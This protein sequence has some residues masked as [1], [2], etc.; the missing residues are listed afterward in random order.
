MIFDI[1]VYRG[2]DKS[3][4]LAVALP[5]YPRYHSLAEKVSWFKPVAN[6]V[7]FWVRENEEVIPE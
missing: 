1:L 4:L 5:D 3:V 2:L 6:F 7:Y